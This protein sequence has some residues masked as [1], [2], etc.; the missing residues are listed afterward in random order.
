M[1]DWVDS[2]VALP[3]PEFLT[4]STQA[5]TTWSTWYCAS[6]ANLITARPPFLPPSV[7]GLYSDVSVSNIRAALCRMFQKALSAEFPG[8]KEGAKVA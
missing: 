5:F 7:S 6:A 2:T 3:K 1:T 8:G 4:A